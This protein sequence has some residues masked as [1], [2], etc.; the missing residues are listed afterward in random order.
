MQLSGTEWFGV[1]FTTSSRACSPRVSAATTKSTRVSVKSVNIELNH[2][3]HE[4]V[5]KKGCFARL[6]Q[7][8]QQEVKGKKYVTR[9]VVF[10][11]MS[12]NPF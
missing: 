11:A 5:F 10:E 1:M 9:S 8:Q 4:G 12:T 6:K 3:V 2:L 7:F